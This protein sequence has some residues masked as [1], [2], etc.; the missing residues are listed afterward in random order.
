MF[1]SLITLATLSLLLGSSIAATEEILMVVEISRHGARESSKIFNFTV[2][3][4]LNFNSTGNI[5]PLGKKQHFELGQLIKQKYIVNYPLLSEN[6]SNNE[7]FVQTTF[8]QR[9]YLSSL[10]QLMGMY[11]DNQPSLSDYINY[12]IGKEDYLSPIQR[13][14]SIKPK[15]NTFNVMQVDADQDFLLHVDKDNC[16]RYGAVASL[17]SSSDQYKNVQ[18]YFTDNYKD[19]LQQLTN[20]TISTVKEMVDICGYLQWAELAN[21]SLTFKP[22]PE[23]DNY[24]LAL[25]DSKLYSVSYGLD[26]L[27]K[28]GSFEFLNKLVYISNALNSDQQRKARGIKSL[29]KLPKMIH[30]AAHA[31]TIA[32]FFDGL[33]IHRTVRSFPGSALFFEFVKVDGKL[34]IRMYYYNAQTK[35]EES[36]RFPTQSSDKIQLMDFI[37]QVKSRLNQIAFSDVEAECKN[38]NFTPNQNDYYSGDA[39]LNDLKKCYPLKSK[40]LT[41]FLQAF[42]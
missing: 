3:P 21:L 12:D 14:G 1:K 30:Y 34:N 40:Q 29:D 41:G 42:E 38:T 5:M 9:T 17:T 19:Q 4:A 31:E 27:W 28:L 23:D 2:D 26:E 36:I 24:C 37:A 13:T 39:L 32:A 18:K 16:P 6:Y 15:T 35:Q 10:Y 7:M 11:P 22:K 25:G 33:G 8:K 20:T